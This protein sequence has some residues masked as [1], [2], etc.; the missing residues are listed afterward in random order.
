V[1]ELPSGTD[2]LE[3]GATWA[4]QINVGCGSPRFFNDTWWVMATTFFTHPDYPEGWPVEVLN[5]GAVDGP[6]AIISATITLV[7]VDRIEVSLTDG[8]AVAVYEPGE[9]FFCG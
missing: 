9:P 1:P 3:I 6:D 4:T 8:T 2:H 5:Q 7:A